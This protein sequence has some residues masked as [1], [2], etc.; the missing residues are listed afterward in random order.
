M[1]SRRKVGDV[2]RSPVAGVSR[3]SH[4][5]LRQRLM[6]SVAAK[7]SA[8]RQAE[9]AARRRAEAMLAECRQRL[10][11]I[12]DS[13][14]D[15]I[16]GIDNEQRIVL[17]N[18]AAEE[19]FGYPAQRILGRPLGALIPC[20]FRAMHAE[21]V[22]EFLATGATARRM[23]ALQALTGLRANGEEFPIEASISQSGLAEGLMAT[24]IVRDIT[25]R[26]AVERALLES[27]QRLA[28]ALEAGGSAVWEL[29][30]ASGVVHTQ[31]QLAEMLGYRAEELATLDDWLALVHREEQEYVAGAFREMIGGGRE[32]D[33]FELRLRARDGSWRWLL[34]QAIVAARDAG[35]RATRIV[36]ATT[37]I[38]D[39]KHA[40]EMMRQNA[41]RDPLTELPNRALTLEFCERLLA[42]SRLGTARSAVL[43]ID[44][45]RFK[46]INDSYGHRVG[47][48]VLKEVAARLRGCV[49]RED[50]VGRLG[51]DEF[52]AVLADIAL[53][54]EAAQG[55]AH[56]LDSLSEPYLV[57]TPLAD[58]PLELRTSPSIGI[59]LYPDHGEDIESLI[60]R[61]DLAMYRAKAAGA[62]TFRFYADE[63][64]VA[65]R[66]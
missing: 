29:D 5:T 51:G 11:G 22:D 20:A 34:S 64:P 1:N 43:F 50:V 10:A 42:G 6:R 37:D 15:A 61:A 3:A 53:P 18:P 38:G 25:A 55:A 9:I 14:M 24:A 7:R 12:V 44:L 26:K 54:E 41:L 13:A 31:G 23:G 66:G 45:D 65:S 46:P 2:E 59:S 4:E 57:A 60:E 36:G 49:R 17:F 39:R 8:R 56:I 27:E 58:T 21:H 30:V 48:A 33:R 28:L 63:V 19:M 62:G 35:G 32:R 52:L 40:E 16:V 47:D